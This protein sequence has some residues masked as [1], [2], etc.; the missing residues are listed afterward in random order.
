MAVVRTFHLPHYEAY[1]VHICL[2]SDVTNAA[3]LRRQLLEANP[4]FDY[5]FLDAS[6]ILTPTHL[7]TATFLALH[8]TLTHRA[9]T[10]TP[11]SELVFRLHP[12]N[13]IGEAY[14]KFGIH[15]TSTHVIAVKLGLPYS[16]GGG[17]GEGGEGEGEEGGKGGEGKDG[18]GEGIRTSVSAASVS[19]HLGDHVQGTSVEISADG[20]NLGRWCDVGKVRKVYKLGDGKAGKGKGKRGGDVGG[21]DGVDGDGDERKEMESVIMG[22]MTI[23]GS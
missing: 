15:D 10:R 23:K 8:S 3:F 17:E 2:F 6:M 11:H 13:N 5:A 12:N 19:K 18:D 22:I 9:K 1:P 16:G 20:G 14:R 4:E 21:M 7:L